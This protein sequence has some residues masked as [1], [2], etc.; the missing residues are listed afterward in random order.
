ME[1]AK[2]MIQ[3]KRAACVNV[4]PAMA[5]IFIWQ[6][7][8][9]KSRETLLIFKTTS[10]QFSALKRRICSMHSYEVPEII[11]FRVHRGLPQYLDWVTRETTTY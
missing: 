5:S 8:V 11:S 6:G 2:S 10:Q 3:E 7:K 4:L 1:I 9:Q